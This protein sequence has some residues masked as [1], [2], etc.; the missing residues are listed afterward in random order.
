MATPN[1]AK[2]ILAQMFAVYANAKGIEA[3]TVAVY[4]RLLQDIPPHELQIVV[5][6]CLAE[7]KFLPTI[8]E[9]RERWHALTRFL[10][11]LTGSEAW[12]QVQAEITRIGSWGSPH[13]EDERIEQAV[14]AIGW[15]N[16]CQSETPGVERAHFI[17]IYDAITERREREQKLL[18]AAR[19]LAAH[20]GLVPIGASLAALVD[21]EREPAESEVAP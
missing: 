7:C 10:P 1:K 4:L 13:F 19:Q 15:M 17:K 18:P 6:Q 2:A 14:K 9:I 8:A 11:A 3:G 16:I 5:D 20:R 12:G 21:G